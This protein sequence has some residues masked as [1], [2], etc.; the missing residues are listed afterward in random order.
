MLFFRLVGLQVEFKLIDGPQ[1]DQGQLVALIDL[2]FYLELEV[3]V[4]W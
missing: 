4:G 1:T 2:V 3:V